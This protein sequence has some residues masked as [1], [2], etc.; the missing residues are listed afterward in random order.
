MSRPAL[1]AA[2]AAAAL[3]AVAAWMLMRP[4]PE[5]APTATTPAPAEPQA[6]G[7]LSEEEERAVLLGA[8]STI[9]YGP[10][11]LG[12][13]VRETEGGAAF[14]FPSGRTVHVAAPAGTR[15]LDEFVVLSAQSGGFFLETDA[16][17]E[18]YFNFA[19]AGRRIEPPSA[20]EEAEFYRSAAERIASEGRLPFLDGMLS[21]VSAT[22]QPE[23]VT[24]CLE[25][26][27]GLRFEG[28]TRFVGPL[29]VT[30]MRVGQCRSDAGPIRDH[31]A[32]AESALAGNR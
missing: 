20:A 21:V 7:A 32:L 15:L 5:D 9:G 24:Y 6:S 10:S 8:L 28:G 27:D 29:S 11:E 26:D 13:T 31:L 30:V 18:V 12:T 19:D 17:R 3:L 1:L 4:V 2:V 14:D 25:R 22:P 16:G 23:S